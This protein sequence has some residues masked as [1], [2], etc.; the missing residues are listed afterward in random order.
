MAARFPQPVDYVRKVY[1]HHAARVPWLVHEQVIDLGSGLG[2]LTKQALQPICERH[3]ARILGLD[4]AEEA[5]QYAIEHNHHRDVTYQH[6]KELSSRVPLQLRGLFSKVFHCGRIPS[7]QENPVQLASQLLNDGGHLILLLP[8]DTCLFPVLECLA[9][10]LRWKA[11]MLDSGRLIPPQ[12]YW[13]DPETEFLKEAQSAGLRVDSVDIETTQVTISG[14]AL[15]HEYLAW[16]LPFVARVPQDQRQQFLDQ[17]L[18]LSKENGVTTL[19]DGGLCVPI[20][21]L[22]ALCTKVRNP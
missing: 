16:A 17:A 19:A 13:E 5:V 7:R 21:Y 6:V 11:Y 18:Q 10:S 20:I 3:F 9:H 2:L 22:S 15:F 14:T 8:L 1:E 4:F 12:Y